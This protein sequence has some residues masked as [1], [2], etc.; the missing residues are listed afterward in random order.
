LSGI[1][2][3]A[4]QTIWYGLSNIVGRFINYLLTPILTYFYAPAQFGDISILFAYAAFLNIIF[5]YGMETSYFRFTQNVEEKKVFNTA[6]TSLLLSTTLFCLLLLLPV[7]HVANFM[8]IGKHPEYVIYVVGIVA[9]DTLAVLPFSKIRFEGRPR[10]F[11]LIKLINIL[12]NFGLVVFILYVLKPIHQNNAKSFLGGLYD[13]KIGIGYIFLAGLAASVVTLLLL[14]KEFKGYAPTFDKKLFIELLVYST[15]LIIVGFGGMINET[16]DRFMIVQRFHGTVEAAK[17]ANGIY[18][19]NNKL[20]IL[21]VIF[22]QTFR[23]GAEPFFFKHSSKENAKETYARIMNIF[24]IATCLC[25]LGVVLFL[26]VW[27][28]FM[29]IKKHPEYLQGLYIVP[30]LMLSKLFLGIYYNLSIWY[31]LTNRN[32][33]GAWITFIGAFI[34][35]AVNYF[36][37]PSLG[38]LACAIANFLCY[39]SMMWISYAM[40]QKHYPIPYNVK[41]SI[42]Y[43][44]FACGLFIIHNF[45]RNSNPGIVIVHTT[46]VFLSTLFAAVVVIKEKAEL[47]NIPIIQRIYKR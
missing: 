36:F 41:K 47:Q 9:F 40:G 10:K 13:P 12:I 29:G 26:D 27:K 2:Q 18:S 39:G 24:V 30:L 11:A 23:M 37:I 28:N 5:T 19:A 25:F 20:A 33:I 42:S 44:F 1:K 34:T 45:I 31:K 3:L 32:K 15:P 16:I 43:I 17:S 46:G 8:E 22:I 35:I 7:Q 21:I 14:S 38:F 4:N 6:F